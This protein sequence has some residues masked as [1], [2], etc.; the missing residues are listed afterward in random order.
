MEERVK[1]L[2]VLIGFVCCPILSLFAQYQIDATESVHVPVLIKSLSYDSK[3][4][5]GN[6]L[7][8]SRTD[9][10]GNRNKASSLFSGKT[11]KS[12]TLQAFD[13]TYSGKAALASILD[14]L[15]VHLIYICDDLTAAQVSE[16]SALCNAKSILSISGVTDH[17][18][19]GLVSLSVSNE[20]GKTKT[21]L[22]KTK[23]RAEGHAFSAQFLQLCK[24]V[25]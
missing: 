3:L 22:N 19:T 14:N 8:L 2:T 20:G 1:R 10:N 13:G 7:I 6:L 15:G 16:I 21:F 5:G 11:I 4:K 9:E 17:V 24:I 23:M 25:E 12:N 18:T